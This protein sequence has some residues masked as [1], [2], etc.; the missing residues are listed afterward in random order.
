MPAYTFKKGERLSSRKSITSLF[1]NGRVQ[2]S[3]PVRIL[4]QPIEGEGY[5]AMMAVSIPKRYFK[6]AV[7]RNLLKRRIREI[8]RL[9][10]PGFYAQLDREGIKIHLV[11]QYQ[12]TEIV[13]FHMLEKGIQEG[14]EKVMADLT[15]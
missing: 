15:G 8:Y 3:P 7:D 9:Y 12:K 6:R 10:K 5:P 2:V 4:Y 11:I 1:K 13:S 14:L